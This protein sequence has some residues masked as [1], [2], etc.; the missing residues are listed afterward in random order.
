[1]SSQPLNTSDNTSGMPRP[2]KLESWKEIAAYLNRTVRTARRWEELEG[3]PVHR[4]GHEKQASVYAYREE[5]DKWLAERR[6]GPA[7]PV[8]RELAAVPHHGAASPAA[9]GFFV[10]RWVVIALASGALGLLLLV[11]Y[12]IYFAKWRFMI[13]L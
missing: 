8:D 3:L 1:M 12:G 5:I 7:Q 4:H 11:L 10:P 9:V 6:P 13:V 2:G